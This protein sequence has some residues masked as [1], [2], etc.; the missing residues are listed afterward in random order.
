MSIIIKKTTFNKRINEIRKLVL[1]LVNNN[2]V[3]CSSC[4]FKRNTITLA[5]YKGKKP[6]TQNHRDWYF[7]THKKE[8]NAIYFEI[9]EE[10]TSNFKLKQA[11]FT[12]LVNDN[13]YNKEILSLHIDPEEINNKYKKGPHIHVKSS[14]N[15]ISKA[16]FSLNLNNL[17]KVINSYDEFKKSYYDAL[18]MINTELL[19]K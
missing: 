18:E 16:H 14:I 9:C 3:A 6:N 10:N 13:N 15:L 5:T 4:A 19:H 11:Y 17:N 2:N 7:T 12:L 1:P 8:Y